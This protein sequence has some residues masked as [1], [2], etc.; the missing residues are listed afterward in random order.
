M[1]TAKR[2]LAHQ[3]F[4]KYLIAKRMRRTTERSEILDATLRRP[5]VF[6]VDA[7]V[8]DI[9]A[10]RHM[11]IARMTVYATL[12]LL[13]MCGL[14]RRRAF[15]GRA[16]CFESTVIHSPQPSLQLVCRKCGKVKDMKCNVDVSALM[17]RRYS[18]FHPDYIDIILQ[19]VCS[20]CLRK[21]Q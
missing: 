6:T 1:D 21:R 13:A 9:M 12:D 4:E 3:T 16:V 20:S 8:D 10:T 19:G 15:K 7:I 2:E 18:G 17:S 5:D 11:H 14:V